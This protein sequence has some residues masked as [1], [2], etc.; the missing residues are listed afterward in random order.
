MRESQRDSRTCCTFVIH[1]TFLFLS[2]KLL[3]LKKLSKVY[4]Q[5]LSRAYQARC[6]G[7]EEGSH[8]E[9]NLIYATLLGSKIV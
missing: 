8:R 3:F 1:A 4:I 9:I 6:M 5:Y 7:D 2:E